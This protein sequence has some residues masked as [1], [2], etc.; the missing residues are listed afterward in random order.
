MSRL[1]TR[2]ALPVVV[3]ATLAGCSGDKP[4]GPP[5]PPPPPPAPVASNITIE[6][7]DSQTAPVAAPLGG[8]LVVLVTDAQGQP[9]VGASVTWSVSQGVADLSATQTSTDQDGTTSI[10]VVL[11]ED[12]GL[13][14]IA[15]RLNESRS[16]T[17]TVTGTPLAPDKLEKLGGDPSDLMAGAST[18]VSV[19]VTDRFSNAIPGTTVR[20]TAVSGGGSVADAKSISDE[21]GVASATWTTGGVGGALNELDALIDGTSFSIRFSTTTEPAVVIIDR[22]NPSVAPFTPPIPGDITTA[23]SAVRFDLNGSVWDANGI[24]SAIVAVFEDDSSGNLDCGVTDPVADLV[25]LEDLPGGTEVNNTFVDV[26]ATADG[27]TAS[28]VITNPNG[29]GGA[30]IM[31]TYCLIVFADDNARSK[32]GTPNPNSNN[33]LEFTGTTVEVGT[34]INTDFVQFT[35]SWNP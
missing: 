15:A 30:N 13:R 14:S 8:P 24:S 12:A 32:D 11:G 1:T 28:F 17:F 4:T 31:V 3:L 10:D 16:V 19:R 33:N 35:V 22:T 34:E 21:N 23:V 9:F 26:T 29:A 18:T 20:W 7:G 6:S 25:L 2:Y 5:P 27:F